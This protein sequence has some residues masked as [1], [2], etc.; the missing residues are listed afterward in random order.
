MKEPIN[1]LVVPGLEH[2]PHVT[3]TWVIMALFILLAVLVRKSLNPKS[4]TGAYNLI[5]S[6]VVG[7]ISFSDSVIGK[8][9]RPYFPLLATLGLFILIANI[10]GLIPG[11]VS[12]TANVN[13]NAAMAITVFL[14][15]Q[16][17]GLS[18]HGFRYIKHFLGPSPALAILLFPIEIISH[19]ARPVTLTMRLF[20][21]IKGEDLVILVLGF[22]IPLL[23]PVP[24]LAFALFTSV[25]QAGIFVLLTMVYL[26]GALDD[27]H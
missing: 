7:L 21:N 22:L 24:M 1:Y 23:L 15:Y 26:A 4:P 20:G 11:A 6:L 9:G 13:T 27:A 25:L 8:E 19:L 12:P 14:V 3:Y 5:D 16:Y 10:F 2:Y 17:A 18:K